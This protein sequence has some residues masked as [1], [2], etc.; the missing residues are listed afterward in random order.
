MI[1]PAVLF[2][3]KFLV[4]DSIRGRNYHPYAMGGIDSELFMKECR[5]ALK[6]KFLSSRAPFNERY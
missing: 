4:L 3:G 2:C 1:L 6:S 5:G